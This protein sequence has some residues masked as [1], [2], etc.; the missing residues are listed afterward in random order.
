MLFFFTTCFEVPMVILW[1]IVVVK[2]HLRTPGAR[3]AAK[4]VLAILLMY[5]Q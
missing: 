3:L 2:L 4:V 5:K 1:V